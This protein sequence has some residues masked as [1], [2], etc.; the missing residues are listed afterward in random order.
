MTE[1]KPTKEPKEKTDETGRPMAVSKIT[2]EDKYEA[3][4]ARVAA[5]E[6]IVDTHQRYH[7]G[8]KAE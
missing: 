1:K 4:E 6:K 2:L 7:F 8:R 5:M 3:L